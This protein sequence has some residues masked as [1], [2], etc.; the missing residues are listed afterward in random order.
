MPYNF[1]GCITNALEDT[2][3]KRFGQGFDWILL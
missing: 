3:D 2:K 1:G